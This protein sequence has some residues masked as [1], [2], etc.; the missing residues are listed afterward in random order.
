MA[1]TKTYSICTILN[2]NQKEIFDLINSGKINET[3]Q[4]C[5]ELLDD[6]RITDKNA[7]HKAKDIFAKKNDNLFLSSL[8]TYMT[9]MTVS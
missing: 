1:K 9:C 3:R 7:V 6:P 2:N 5:I 8:M 4:K